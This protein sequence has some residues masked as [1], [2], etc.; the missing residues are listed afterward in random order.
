MPTAG[1]KKRQLSI[2]RSFEKWILKRVFRKL[3][4]SSE[5][6]VVEGGQPPQDPKTKVISL[7][8]PSLYRTLQILL[9]PDIMLG[10]SYVDGFWA[11][12][13]YQ[14]FDFLYLIRSQESSNLQ[15]WFVLSNRFHAIRDIFKQRLF[16]IRST[17]AVVEHYN[18][19]PVFMSYILGPSLSYTCAFFDRMDV[20]L[21]EAQDNKVRTVAERLALS[22]QDDVL[23]LGCGWGNPAI[24]LA[25]RYGCTVT[26]LTISQAQLD[27]CNARATASLAG[28]RLRFF[29]SDFMNF[30]SPLSYDK[31]ISVGMLEH[32]GKYQYRS[33][34]DKVAGFLSDTGIALIHSMVEE[35]E[36]SPDAW[37]DKNIFPGGYIP[38]AS[39]VV[40]GIEA[41]RCEL[42]ELFIH[43]KANYFQTLES[44]KANLFANQN[45]CV[46]VLKKKGLRDADT[47]IIIRVWEYFLSS[48]QISFSKKYGDCRVAHFL[49]RAKHG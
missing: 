20:S 32:L 21:E 46:D 5:F 10:Q 24:P 28:E 41:S 44:W 43:A 16:P 35:S 11:V 30:E 36:R 31:I 47:A 7:R 17:R 39:E 26:G 48:S 19:D 6:T 34:F 42:V 1:K 25:E 15:K 38:T 12:P 8:L 14:L 49:V 33:F 27:F 45:A 9:K 29:K 13:P 40:A 4:Q 18:T 22:N 37:I 3:L 23:D 2:L